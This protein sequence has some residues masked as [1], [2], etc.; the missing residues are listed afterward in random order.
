MAILF[1]IGLAVGGFGTFFVNDTLLVTE[2]KKGNIHACE[3][4]HDT[5][6]GQ[7]HKPSVK[8]E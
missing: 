6:N 2:C 7:K 3:I 8:S 1:F 4:A 5:V